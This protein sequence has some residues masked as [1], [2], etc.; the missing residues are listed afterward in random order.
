MNS[1]LKKLFGEILIIEEYSRNRN[2][3][4]NIILANLIGN[5]IYKAVTKYNKNSSYNQSRHSARFLSCWELCRR[6]NFE[7]LFSV[8][9]VNKYK[10]L[11]Q[12]FQSISKSDSKLYM[13]IKQDVSQSFFDASGKYPI[14]NNEKYIGE[15]IGE[16]EKESSLIYSNSSKFSKKF[17]EDFYEIKFTIPESENEGKY[18]KLLDDYMLNTDTGSK[19]FRDKLEKKNPLLQTTI[20]GSNVNFFLDPHKNTLNDYIQH[21]NFDYSQVKDDNTRKLL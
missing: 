17:I 10:L 18:K 16:Y 12:W 3:V 13:Y 9:K 6:N 1:K 11:L 15:A 20:I 2:N 21:A 5:Q 7:D 14:N 19:R 8:E 4:Q